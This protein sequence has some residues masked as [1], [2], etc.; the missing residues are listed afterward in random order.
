[1]DGAAQTR[2][3]LVTFRAWERVHVHEGSRFPEDARQDGADFGLRVGRTKS[4]QGQIHRKQ[5]L[6][7]LHGLGNRTENPRAHS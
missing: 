4:F 6:T 2:S 5:L 1:M 3:G 7:H